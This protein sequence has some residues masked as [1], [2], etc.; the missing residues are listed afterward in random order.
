VQRAALR[1]AVHCRAGA[2]AATEYVSTWVPGAKRH[3]ECRIAPGTRGISAL[4]QSSTDTRWRIVQSRAYKPQQQ[5]IT[6][7]KMIKLSKFDAADYLDSQEMIAAYL[8]EA[9]EI[10]DTD[11]IYHA[12]ETIARAKGMT[13]FVK[14]TGIGPNSTT[15]PEFETV[16][17]AIDSFGLKLI[18]QPIA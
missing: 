18:A 1:G 6:V 3:E 9:L 14:D 17:K 5:R 16:Q 4:K 13:D 11:F 2:H 8:N 7:Q 12:L 10:G 15:K